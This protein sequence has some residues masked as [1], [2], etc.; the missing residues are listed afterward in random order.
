[1][2][3]E[4]CPLAVRLRALA[5]RKPKGTADAM[6]Q[7]AATSRSTKKRSNQAADPDRPLLGAATWDAMEESPI[8]D[9][10]GSGDSCGCKSLTPKPTKFELQ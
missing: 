2:K 10:G 5:S 1:L 6:N 8:I 9:H 7:T 4:I 3:K